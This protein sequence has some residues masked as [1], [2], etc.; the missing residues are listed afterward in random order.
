MVFFSM[1]PLTMLKKT[2]QF[3]IQISIRW[4]QNYTYPLL[5]KTSSFVRM[6]Q[7]VDMELQKSELK[8]VTRE[9][10]MLHVEQQG[11]KRG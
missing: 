5:I 6:R 11:A 8:R 3:Q 1:E 4:N 7:I 2:V 9:R 10:M